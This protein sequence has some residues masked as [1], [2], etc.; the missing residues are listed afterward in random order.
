[1]DGPNSGRTL[2]LLPRGDV[3]RMLDRGFTNDNIA[4][5]QREF[6]PLPHRRNGPDENQG[7]FCL[8]THA[9]VVLDI[10]DKNGF[11]V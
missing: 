5:R 1:M 10:I 8:W 3:K 11:G 4:A 2:G 6:E 9:R 7:L